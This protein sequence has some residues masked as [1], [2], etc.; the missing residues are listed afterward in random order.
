[1]LI[2]GLIPLSAFSSVPC[3]LSGSIDSR[4]ADCSKNSQA[5]L[6]SFVLVTEKQNNRIY[7][8]TKT[9][10]LWSYPLGEEEIN[11]FNNKCNWLEPK[12]MEGIT[13]VKWRAPSKDDYQT[14]FINGILK[15][16][17]IYDDFWANPIMGP[18][19]YYFDAYNRGE[20]QFSCVVGRKREVQCI[21][22]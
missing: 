5:V 14:A 16:P 19:A 15:L 10:L 13:G 8:D 12:D 4:I 2:L 11:W 1:M 21:A 20:I 7:K 18:C 9:G 22:E 3:G 6:D 17:R